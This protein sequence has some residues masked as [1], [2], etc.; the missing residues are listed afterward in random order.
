MNKTQRAAVY[1]LFLAGLLLLLP[2]ID[3]LGT[4]INPIMLRVISYSLIVLM[5]FPVW[6]LSRK[7][8]KDKVEADEHDRIIVKK[9]FFIAGC[10]VCTGLLIL[11]AFLIFT[12][13]PDETVR[14]STLLLTV[15]FSFI[16]FLFIVSSVV[17]VQYGR[18]GKDA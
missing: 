6:F 10:L 11:Y 17:L 5:V 3:L 18:G 16:A 1:G 13:T 15:F 14:I 8:K 4:K 9:A 12:R 2:L 7:Y